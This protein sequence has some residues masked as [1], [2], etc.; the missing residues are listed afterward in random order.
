M[1]Q[2]L[3][4]KAG[5]VQRAGRYRRDGDHGEVLVQ[6][7]LTSPLQTDRSTPQV[8]RQHDP[9]GKIGLSLCL[10]PDAKIVALTCSNIGSTPPWV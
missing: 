4:T 9:L 10:D 3:S 8:N 2:C 5:Q 7:R 1:S 6:S